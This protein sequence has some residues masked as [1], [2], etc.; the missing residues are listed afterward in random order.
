[1]NINKSIGNEIF[2]PENEKDNIINNSKKIHKNNTIMKNNLLINEKK[3]TFGNISNGYNN[4][5]KV[6]YIQNKN[7]FSGKENKKK[8]N[9]IILKYDNDENTIAEAN[10]NNI[11]NKNT[12]YD[13]N[14]NKNN[15]KH[16]MDNISNNGINCNNM[17][18]S[19]NN[20]KVN[21][22][23]NDEN[24]NIIVY[25]MENNISNKNINN[26]SSPNENAIVNVNKSTILEENNAENNN[27]T[28]QMN[29]NKNE[30]SP[31][32]D[33]INSNENFD[34]PVDDFGSFLLEDD[35]NLSRRAY[36][37][38][39]LCSIFIHLSYLLMVLLLISI[40]CYDIS[41]FHVLNKEKN[42]NYL[43]AVLLGLLFVHICINL[44]TSYKLF[45]QV[46]VSKYLKIFESYIHMIAI[47]FFSICLYIYFFRKKNF[48]MNSTFSFTILLAAI[49]Y[50]LPLFL[51]IILHIVFFVVIITLFIIRRKS[52][53]PKRILKKLKIMK[54]SE[55]RKYCEEKYSNGNCFYSDID[56]NECDKVENK[57]DKLKEFPKNDD[58]EVQDYKEPKNRIDTVNN[59]AEIWTNST[60]SCTH[61]INVNQEINIET[62]KHI[63]SSSQIND[64]NTRNKLENVIIFQDNKCK[65]AENPDNN[66]VEKNNKKSYISNNINII[67]CNKKDRNN[68]NNNNNNFN[69]NDNYKN[70]TNNSNYIDDSYN[71]DNS[72]NNNNNNNNDNNNNNSINRTSICENDESRND[73]KIKGVLGYFK[74]VLK[75]KKNIIEKQKIENS[76][77]NSVRINIENSDFVCSICCIEYFN[78]D[79]ICI[80]PCNYLHY[81]HKECI[82]TWLKRNNDCPL[83]RKNIEK[84]LKKKKKKLNNK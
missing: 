50:F 78:D 35:L 31:E 6:E 70:T 41:K 61:N 49:Y 4:N 51:Y 13:V 74:R 54:Y 62:D 22:K 28:P 68:I 72:N 14:L 76:D 23:L 45:R 75:K 44:C 64:N 53:T 12:N 69:H 10:I 16:K 43:C 7:E 32:N 27:N 58:N 67:K 63:L 79:D 73:V 42:V 48:P 25:E 21:G 19:T 80:L 39:H 46:E 26:I 3:G 59:H 52:P 38:F 83:C 30:Q 37:N 47:L 8:Q 24:K 40:F 55:Y 2:I 36:R 34:D 20:I 15:I 60:I 77:D 56:I 1:M 9:G 65:N 17:N 33:N 82:F 57:K 84:F 66:D 11:F 18:Y 81:Y 5:I 29:D 71:N